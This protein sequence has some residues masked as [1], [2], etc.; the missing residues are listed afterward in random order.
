MPRPSK[1]KRVDAVP[2]CC[3]FRGDTL[4]RD[5]FYIALTVEEYETVRLI[6]YFGKTQEECAA[7]M[8]IGRGTVQMLYAEARKKL[9][10]FLVEGCTLLIRGGDYVV[11]PSCGWHGRCRNDNPDGIDSLETGGFMTGGSSARKG[12]NCMTI[13]V[14][15]DNGEIF[16]HFGHTEQFKL[17]QVENGKVV[18]A[19][20]LDTNGS[21]HG[22]LAGFLKEHGVDVLI[23]GGIGGG[24]RNAL[25]DAGIQLFGGACGSADAQVESYLAG[26]LS[27]DPDVRCS[28]HG[29][30]EGNCHGH[31]GDGT[32]GAHGCH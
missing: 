23:C 24:A 6:D 4:E 21:G 22:A 2:R 18:S 31:H 8:G 10:R 5:D 25:A 14:T 20:V 29:H 3:R 27:Y 26:T 28:H 16:Q 7:F 11:K 30:G 19:Q 9:A 1:P 13:A 12:E 15:Y 32:C 17:Y